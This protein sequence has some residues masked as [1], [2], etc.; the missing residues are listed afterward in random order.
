MNISSHFQP[1]CSAISFEMTVEVASAVH[2][3]DALDARPGAGWGF[4][5]HPGPDEGV[6][7]ARPV[8]RSVYWAGVVALAG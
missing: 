3:T 1:H 8:I 6:P 7:E 5:P 4:C 2:S